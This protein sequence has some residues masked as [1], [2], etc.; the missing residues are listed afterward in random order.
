MFKSLREVYPGIILGCFLAD[1]LT[2]NSH[3]HRFVFS[4]YILICHRI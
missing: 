4:Q 3:Q 1:R 2:T